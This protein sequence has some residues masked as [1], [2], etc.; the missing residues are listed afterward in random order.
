MGNN[1]KN[2]ARNEKEKMEQSFGCT[3][4]DGDEHIIKSTACGGKSVEKEDAETITVYLWS[5]NL[6]EKYAPYIQ[7][8]L[9]DPS[10]S[11]LRS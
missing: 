1:L 7:E 6:Y 4:N 2:G 10:Q 3:F 5:T 9:P 11:L 8:Q